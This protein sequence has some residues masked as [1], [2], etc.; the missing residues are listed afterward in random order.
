MV[1]IGPCSE[2]SLIVTHLGCKS[3][4]V[5]ITTRNGYIDCMF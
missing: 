4:V 2:I 1:V 3:V 5:Y